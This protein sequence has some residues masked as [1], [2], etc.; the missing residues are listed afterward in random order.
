MKLSTLFTLTLAITLV[1]CASHPKP[2]VIAGS[3]TYYAKWQK[4]VLE[5]CNNKAAMIT[6]KIVDEK[7][8]E[9]YIVLESDVMAIHKYLVEKCSLDSGLVI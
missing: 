2:I 6:L 4:A 3:G 1:G 5:E 9:G 7:I 8:K